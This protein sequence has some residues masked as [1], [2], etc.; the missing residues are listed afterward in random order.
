MC[1]MS[2][3]HFLNRN[4]CNILFNHLPWIPWIIHPYFTCQCV[5]QQKGGSYTYF[6]RHDF[7]FISNGKAAL[8]FSETLPAPA[9]EESILFHLTLPDI[10]FSFLSLIVFLVDVA[11]DLWAVVELYKDE[12]YF[13]MGFLIF[14]LLGSSVLTQI[15]SWIWYSEQNKSD[16]KTDVENFVKRH[17]LLGPVHIFQLGIVL[18]F[19]RCSCLKLR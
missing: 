19:V 7:D 14:L 15:Y 11:L 1:G 10:C 18:R 16:P 17:S 13:S 9:M 8:G 5:T 12:K 4:I 3:N 6:L 2:K